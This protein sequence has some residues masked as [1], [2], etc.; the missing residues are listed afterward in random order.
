MA[1]AKGPFFPQK[2]PG[3]TAVRLFSGG[4]FMRCGCG[5]TRVIHGCRFKAY[6][7]SESRLIKTSPLIAWLQNRLALVLGNGKSHPGS[8]GYVSKP[9]QTTHLAMDIMKYVEKSWNSGVTVVYIHI[10]RRAD[11]QICIIYIYTRVC[12]CVYRWIDR[13]IP[14]TNCNLQIYML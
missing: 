11:T 8:S 7:D 12:V 13:S 4:V 1:L 14:F 6:P 10:Y 5:G 2:W 9:W 3:I